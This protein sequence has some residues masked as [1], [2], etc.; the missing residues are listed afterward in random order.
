[1][2]NSYGISKGHAYKSL[3]NSNNL[4]IIDGIHK[5]TAQRRAYTMRKLDLYNRFKQ[6]QYKS[7][8]EALRWRIWAVKADNEKD[9]EDYNRIAERDENEAMGIFKAQNAILPDYTGKLNEQ[10]VDLL[11]KY[12]DK[13]DE[14]HTLL[15]VAK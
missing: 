3:Y 11:E 4:Y 1:M 7:D 10:T 6:E 15:E 14:Y 13:K 8:I 9:R 5:Q 2:H 12:L